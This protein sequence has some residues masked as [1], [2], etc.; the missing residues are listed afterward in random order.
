MEYVDD[1][2]YDF[3]GD[4]TK[5]DIYHMTYKEIGYMRLHR[6]KH[7]PREA[8]TLA[9]LLTQPT[10]G[11]PPPQVPQGKVRGKPAT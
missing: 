4:L 5:E 7:H 2:L 1:V 6:K 9:S 3:H 8:D 11:T 10:G